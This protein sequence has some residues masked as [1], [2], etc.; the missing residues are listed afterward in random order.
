MSAPSKSALRLCLLAGVLVCIYATA[1]GAASATLNQMI[2][3]ARKEGIIRGQWSQNTFGGGEGFN[4]FL[5]GMNKKYGL[6]LK[7]QFTPGPDMQA[8]M[9]RIVQE[10]AAG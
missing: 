1:A 2:E 7:G 3:G 4:D 5:V 8:L 10:A 6:N 9:V